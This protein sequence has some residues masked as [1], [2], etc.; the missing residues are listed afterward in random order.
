MYGLANFADASANKRCVS[1][2]TLDGTYWA[3]ITDLSPESKEAAAV[4][5]SKFVAMG[6]PVLA[7]LDLLMR[8]VRTLQAAALEEYGDVDLC[9]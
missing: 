6:L 8:L 4:A 1:L 3:V 7:S 5:I 9:E 2:C